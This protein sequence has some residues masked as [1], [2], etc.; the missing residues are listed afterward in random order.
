MSDDK[1]KPV[2][3]WEHWVVMHWLSAAGGDRVLVNPKV[4]QAVLEYDR[5]GKILSEEEA[6]DAMMAAAGWKRTDDGKYV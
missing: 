3:T 2:T 4:Y 5:S 1:Q 6:H